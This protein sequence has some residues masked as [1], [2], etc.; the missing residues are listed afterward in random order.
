VARH[1]NITNCC[2]AVTSAAMHRGIC[3]FVVVL[4]VVTAP[5]PIHIARHRIVSAIDLRPKTCTAQSQASVCHRW[6]DGIMIA[7]RG[8]KRAQPTR[9]D[10]PEGS[11]ECRCQRATLSRRCEGAGEHERAAF[12]AREKPV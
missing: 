10:F 8:G 4:K 1:K 2:N 9:L 6:S 11:S 3:K 12:A 5:E 7:R